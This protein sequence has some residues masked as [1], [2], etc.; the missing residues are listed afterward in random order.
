MAQFTA[1]DGSKVTV[2]PSRVIRI[3]QTVYG[4]STDAKTRI[5]W[6]VMSL[7]TEPLDDV[8]RLIKAKLTSPAALSTLDGR[9][10]WFEAK[11]A[12]GP[13]LVTPTQK[14]S[15]FNSSIKI[16][17]YRQ[18]LTETPDEVRFVIKNAGGAPVEA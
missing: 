12:V 10:I 17:G 5:D 14:N 7:V 9:K 13:L 4:E 2:D 15:G 11:Q 3:R 1:P 16:M 6:A 8:V 18:Y